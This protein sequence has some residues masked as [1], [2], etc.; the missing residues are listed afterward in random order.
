MVETDLGVTP[1][2]FRSMLTIVAMERFYRSVRYVVILNVVKGSSG[3]RNGVYV[4]TL[5]VVRHCT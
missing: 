4:S 1:Y 3:I 5:G 2:V